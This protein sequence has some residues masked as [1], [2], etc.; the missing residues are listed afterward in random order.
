MEIWPIAFEFTALRVLG[1][2]LS[3]DVFIVST[4]GQEER[5]EDARKG[6]PRNRTV[7]QG[8]QH[9]MELLPPEGEIGCDRVTS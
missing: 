9:F 8:G 1:A 2:Q 5:C 6:F 7:R 4:Y 3:I